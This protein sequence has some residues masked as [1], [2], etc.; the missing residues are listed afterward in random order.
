MKIIVFLG[1]GASF[2]SG[3]VTFGGAIGRRPPP[4]GNHLFDELCS[5][6]SFF[7]TIPE[8]IKVDFRK[9]F[10]I[11]M[12]SYADSVG[13]EVAEF[14]RRMARFLASFTAGPWNEYRRLVRALK[15]YNVTYVSLNYYLLL[16]QS[17]S[18][19]RRGVR[20]DH[21]F[22]RAE[23]S[24][25]SVLK[26]HGSSNFWPDIP[27]GM[28][29]G[30]RIVNCDV[31]VSSPVRPLSLSETLVRCSED[32]GMS[33]AMA[34]YAK[35]KK[36]FFAPDYVTDQ[37]K[38][39]ETACAEADQIF[40][41]GVRVQPDDEHIWG[42]LSRSDVPLTYF[43]GLSD[44]DEFQA[45][46]QSTSRSNAAFINAYFPGAIDAMHKFT[47]RGGSSERVR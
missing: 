24:Y 21:S 5:Y 10:E 30:V 32:V 8:A 40:V 20:Y 43:G 31:A 42:I 28:L 16:E 22:Y 19:A 36:V 15:F 23:S 41:S 7:D 25:I 6:D 47:R 13:M 37:Q 26:I 39:F 12:A 45:W 27:M 29:Q 1:A 4:L 44:E 35:G 9:N 33:P 38:K 3:D 11:G 14:Q 34:L 2:G 46:R 18:A 17:I